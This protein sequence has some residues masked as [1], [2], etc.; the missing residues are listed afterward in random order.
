MP[1]HH[2][3][4]PTNFI[5]FIFA[6]S[7]SSAAI[8]N[9]IFL[10]YFPY[11]LHFLPL[12]IKEFLFVNQPWICVFVAEALII[13]LIWILIPYYDV[14]LINHSINSVDCVNCVSSVISEV[15]LN[16]CYLLTQNPMLN[17]EVLISLICHSFFTK[18]ISTVSYSLS[19][20]SFK[21]DCLV[22]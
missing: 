22:N 2:L 8:T 18:I 6:F 9:S 7:I 13:S 14:N 19:N 12:H 15:M 21:I 16:N 3:I 20:P 17:F 11:Q 10:H 5:N 1:E 4:I